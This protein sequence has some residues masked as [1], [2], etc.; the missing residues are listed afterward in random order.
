MTLYDVPAPAKINLF[1][2]VT[3]RRP[4]GYHLLETVFRFIGLYDTFDF[5]LR[6]D[7][8][9]VR[10]GDP[11]PGLA[12]DD[13]LVVR[14]A[15]ALQRATGT[16][17]GAQIRYR[18][19]IPAG[20]GLGGGSSDAATVLIALN[21]LWSC[22]LDREQLMA[23]AL[24]L[25]ADVPVFIFGESAFARGIGEELVPVDLPDRAY[26]IV[27]PPETIPTAV[28]FSSPYLTRDS[29]PV[30][31]SVFA[32][33]QKEHAPDNGFFKHGMFGSNVLSSVAQAGFPGVR[34]AEQCLASLGVTPRMS[35]SG[36]CVFVEFENISQAV[37]FKQK[38]FGKI[39]HCN[40]ELAAVIR[41]V[42][43][44]PGLTEHPLKSWVN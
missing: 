43:V 4:D 5:D 23:L 8:L 27:Q 19:A 14:A 17:L 2:H 22:G 6:T 9:I 24:P 33:W 11:V 15:R 30:I 28:I 29:K 26:V 37:L 31:M 25:G 20:G 21:R 41:N 39:Q 16:R 7:G 42:W 40:A 44:C 13:D 10:E 34:A 3:G 1:L 32:D 35:G 18:K 38:I 36:A 12:A